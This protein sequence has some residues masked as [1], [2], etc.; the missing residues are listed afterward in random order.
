MSFS[1]AASLLAC[2]VFAT[3][4]C[5]GPSKAARTSQRSAL[6]EPVR[7]TL[8]TVGQGFAPA[9]WTLAE[10]QPDLIVHFHG[11]PSVV[12]RE[13]TAAGVRAI[14][15]IINYNG[16]SRKYAVPFEDPKLFRRVMDESLAA[17]REKNLVATDASWRRVCV[18]SF[19]AG[20][21]AVRELL[22]VPEYFDRI[23][24][25]LLADT[26]YAGY[27]GPPAEH[28]VNIEHLKEFRRYAQA[29]ADGHK[30]MLMTHSYLEP[31]LYAGTHETAADL[32]AFVHAEPQP[33]DDVVPDKMTLVSKTARGR[34]IVWGFAGKTGEE[35]MEHLRNLR[36]GLVRLPLDSLRPKPAG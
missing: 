3:A 15:V 24:S 31:G 11:A 9:G 22:A 14:L 26:L 1:C 29:A 30:A 2:A 33:T 18:S 12:E 34:F 21:G 20:F 25:L 4:G 8:P 32:I 5:A 17:A 19:S 16:L 10:E 28:R 23:D 13:F 27:D 6:A 35:H 36:F 7:F